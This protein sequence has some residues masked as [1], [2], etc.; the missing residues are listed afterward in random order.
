LRIKY[1]V[2]DVLFNVFDGRVHPSYYFNATRT[3]RVFCKFPAIFR[4]PAKS[5]QV[6]GSCGALKLKKETCIA[7]GKKAE[8]VILDFPGVFSA[9]YFDLKQAEVVTLV[10]FSEDENLVRF[11]N[12]GGDVYCYFGALLSGKSYDEA[13][14]AWQS[15]NPEG[16]RIR[17]LGKKAVFK[18]VYGGRFSF[19]EKK[20]SNGF[21]GLVK[22]FKK[23]EEATSQTRTVGTLFGKVRT[24]EPDEDRLKVFVNTPVQGSTAELFFLI[25][26]LARDEFIKRGLPFRPEFVNQDCCYLDL[27]GVD[28]EKVKEVLEFV[29]EKVSEVRKVAAE[30][31]IGSLPVEKLKARYR[32]SFSF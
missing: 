24:C 27:E 15:G 3:G 17:L 6:C 26:R 9:G 25:L 18:L 1:V 22:W 4:W 5:L 13:F 21:K 16:E 14:K 31:G 2:E 10:N 29:L 7:C 30:L 12:S 32:C 23:V 20:F 19:L 28:P 8:A 11:L